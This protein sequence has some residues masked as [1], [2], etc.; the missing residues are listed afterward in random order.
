[1]T[2]ARNERGFTLISVLLAV[3]MLTIG[4]V[5]LARTQGLLAA[6]ESGVSNRSVAL[7]V[8]TGYLEQLR[9]V[10]PAQLASEA[11]VAVDADGQPSASGPYQRS[12]VV[13]LDQT[14]LVRLQVIVAYPRGPV[15]IELVALLY[16]RTP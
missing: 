4:L 8:A 13:T 5:A 16:R 9:G 1:M 14:N 15:P 3:M 12:T 10:D 6:A 7:A 11:P 2:R